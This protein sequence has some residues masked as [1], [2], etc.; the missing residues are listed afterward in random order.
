MKKF[1]AL[2]CVACIASST[3]GW[4][5]GSAG[6]TN[7]VT[8][9]KALGMGNSFV[10]VADDPSAVY[11]N[12]AGM[13]QLK[14]PSAYLAIYPTNISTDYKADNGTTDSMKPFTAVVP[15]LYLTMPFSGNRWSL[16]FGINFPYGLETHW[17]KSGPLRF[18]ATDSELIHSNYSSVLAY[19]I[20]DGFSV[21]GGI[22]YAQTSASLASQ[23]NVT[24]LNSRLGF[25]S[26]EAEGTNKLEGDG[27]GWGYNLSVLLKPAPEHSVGL[28]YKSEVKTAIEGET[29]LSGLGGA[30]SAVFG[31]SSYSVDTRTD[32][33]FPPSLIFGYAYRPNR[34]TLALDGEWAGYSTVEQQRLEFTG[35]SD[36]TRLAVLNTGNPAPKNWNDSLNYGMGAN[37]QINDNW[38]GRFGF[39]HSSKSIPDSTWSPSNPESSRNALTLGTGY[40][41]RWLTVDVAYNY[42]LFS[43]RTVHNSIAAGTINGSYETTVHV[44]AVGLTFRK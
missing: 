22:T 29:Q 15:N 13:T 17:D 12:P 11:F 14:T 26:V 16:G 2:F 5:V 42:I 20:N 23:L 21:G 4:S 32:I 35:E 7:Q 44:F 40:S 41:K 1:A 38:Q 27:H 37:C 19:K 28:S 31:G 9:V 10:A 3:N 43:K 24:G 8:G 39:Y 36:P 30:S 6:F 34:W 25:P 18:E 33:T